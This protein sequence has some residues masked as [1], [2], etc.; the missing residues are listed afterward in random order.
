MGSGGLIC[1]ESGQL[2]GDLGQYV[3]IWASMWGS[4]PVCGERHPFLREILEL[5]K[6][7][8]ESKQYLSSLR[9]EGGGDEGME[10]FRPCDVRTS[11]N[12]DRISRFL[13]P[14]FLLPRPPLVFPQV[15][16]QHTHQMDR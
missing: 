2:C 14:F 3:G 4:G 13:T 7:L 10:I 8:Q 11:N 5:K 16:S 1:G 6:N 15:W 12:L 9:E